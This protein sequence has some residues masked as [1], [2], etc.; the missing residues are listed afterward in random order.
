MDETPKQNEDS[1]GRSRVVTIVLAKI[2]FV[3]SLWASIKLLLF[4]IIEIVPLDQATKQRI[5]FGLYANLGIVSIL[6]WSGDAVK[7]FHRRLEWATP[8]IV[9]VLLLLSGATLYIL[10]LLQASPP[11]VIH[12]SVAVT[13]DLAHGQIF[14]SWQDPHSGHSKHIRAWGDKLDQSFW[15]I[16]GR[17][18]DEASFSYEGDPRLKPSDGASS[19]G[20][21]AFYDT[22]TDRR[23][24]AK[25]VFSLQSAESCGK[26]KADVGIRLSIDNPLD[27]GSEYFTYELASV[28]KARKGLIDGS[29][30]QFEL[31][32]NEFQRI[33]RVRNSGPL[34]QGLNENTIN[35]VAFFVDNTIVEQCPKN[36]LFIRGVSLQQP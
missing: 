16:A 1:P 23:N 28:K 12:R 33:P 35:K 29:W 20:Y 34:P 18:P 9:L 7:W 2:A 13:F 30:R 27:R 6:I 25:I 26:G 22:P 3:G 31:F 36:T 14:N 24:F 8:W 11:P 21:Q 15:D 19:G 4:P 32:V 10:R 5:E 17:S